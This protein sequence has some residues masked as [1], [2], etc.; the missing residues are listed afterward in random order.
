MDRIRLLRAALSTGTSVMAALVLAAPAAAQTAPPVPP[1]QNTPVTPAPS[2]PVTVERPVAAYSDNLQPQW[3]NIRS[4]WG[5]NTPFW[6]NIR[7]FWGDTGPYAADLSPFW[8]NIRSFNDTNTDSALLPSWGNIRSFA[9]DIGASW[10]NIRSFWGNI[11][12]FQDAP[13]DYVQLAGMISTMRAQSQ[14]TWGSAVQAQTGQSFASGFAD[15]LFTKYGIDL[16]NP[17]SLQNLDPATR[18]HFFMDWWDGL[19]NFSGADHVDHW[20]NEV[21]WSPALTQTLGAG[22]KTVI[23]VLDFSIT[24]DAANNVVKYGGVSTI[25]NGHGTAVASLMVDPMDGKGVMGIAPRAS[26]VEYNPFDASQTAGWSDITN[27]VAYLTKNGATII[28][29]SLGVPG[30]TLNGGWDKVFQDKSV[31]PAAAKQVFVIAAG[32]DGVVQTQNITWHNDNPQ[33]IIVGSVD[34]TGAISS[35]SNQPG[36]ACFGDD[37]GKCGRDAVKL[38]DRFIVAPGEMILV[39]DGQGSTTRLS[40]TSFAAPLVSGTIALIQDRWPWLTDHPKDTTSIVLNSARDL[41]APGVDPVYGH[42]ELDVL[43]AL[44]P[45]DWSRLTIKQVV[46]GKVTDVKFSQLQGANTATQANWEVSGTFFT[47]FENTGESFRDFE[48][49]VSSKL[50]NQTVAVGG[51]QVQFMGYLTS[52]FNSWIAAP[53]GPAGPAPKPGPKFT[54][55]RGTTHHFRGFGGSDATLMMRPKIVQPGF[56]SSDMPFESSLRL[57]SQDQGFA[58]EFGNGPG[59]TA[60]SGLTGFGMRSDYDLQAGGANPFL[61]LASG[62]AY[63]QV[64]LKLAPGVQLS[65]GI[66]QRELRRDLDGMSLQYRTALGV[67]RSYRAQALNTS[68]TL[69]P[70]GR[71]R[72]SLGYT[73][74]HENDAILGM[75]SVVPTDLPRGSTTD[76]ATLGSNWAITPTFDVSGSATIGRTRAGRVGIDPLAIGN[77]GLVSSSFQMAISKGHLLSGDDHLRLTLAQPMHV[78]GGAVALSNVEVVDRQTGGLGVVTRNGTVTSPARRYVAE[79]L[80]GRSMLDGH[81]NVSLFGR[82]TMHAQAADQIPSLMGGASLSVTF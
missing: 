13:Q 27:G 43:A 49:P 1:P 38:M 80:Y 8:G 60:L 72:A 33:I 68:V 62:G 19:M 6:G 69:Q 24:G 25:A 70:T 52:R 9:G 59:A 14:A 41:G 11:R 57:A 55:I 51:S 12:S 54:D 44:S 50:A 20:M 74:L 76:V 77:A 5:D 71:L 56:R 78:E 23:G 53:S 65:T 15:P 81:G 40:G 58:V 28:N 30:W 32:N 7:S 45:L 48:V 17:A 42:G 64:E 29:M 21:N 36:T 18:E 75:G 10:G 35:F 46:G 4:F 82:A 16:A 22:S 67:P 2:A 39:S 34:P 47:L 26:V 31:K 66:T 79:M 73:L 37:K 3:G 63:S 61:G